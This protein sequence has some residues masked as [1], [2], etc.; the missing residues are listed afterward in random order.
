MNS[1]DRVQHAPNCDG[2]DANARVL[3]VLSIILTGYVV[4]RTSSSIS[5]AKPYL[6][7][8]ATFIQCCKRRSLRETSAVSLELWYDS[9]KT[10]TIEVHGVNRQVEFAWRTAR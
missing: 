8:K 1:G 4:E 6:G 2:E 9:D 7:V 5:S 10:S 3:N